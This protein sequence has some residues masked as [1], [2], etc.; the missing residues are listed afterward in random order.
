MEIA[1]YKPCPPALRLPFALLAYTLNFAF[2]AVSCHHTRSFP[3]GRVFVNS[4]QLPVAVLVAVSQ[5]GVDPD[6]PCQ[7]TSPGIEAGGSHCQ[8][9]VKTA[10]TNCWHYP[11]QTQLRRMHGSLSHSAHI[12]ELVDPTRMIVVYGRCKHAMQMPLV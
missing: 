10:D 3:N 9:P 5:R 8:S 4:P 7:L 11:E 6:S 2:P 1:L 12:E